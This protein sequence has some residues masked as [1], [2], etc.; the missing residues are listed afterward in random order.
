MY[1][2]QLY[3]VQ[4]GLSDPP[5]Y[6][7]IRF[8]ELTPGAFDELV[9]IS[10]RGAVFAAQACIEPMCRSGYGGQVLPESA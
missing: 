4:G 9:A 8:A 6:P 3:M 7:H 1:H 5:A 10:V 2:V